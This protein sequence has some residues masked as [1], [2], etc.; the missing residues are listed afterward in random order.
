MATP[1]LTIPKAEE[2]R[3]VFSLFF[4]LKYLKMFLPVDSLYS[5]VRK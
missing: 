2:L 3:L 1:S 5:E 4:S